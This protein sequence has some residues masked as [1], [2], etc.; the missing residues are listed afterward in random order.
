MRGVLYSLARSFLFALDPEVA[1][2]LTLSRLDHAAA[3]GLTRLVCRRVP[4]LPV[5][6]MGLDFRNPVGLAAGMDKNAAH[7]DALGSFGFGHIEA[8]TVTPRPQ[9]GNPKPRLFRLVPAQGLINRMGFNNDGVERFVAHVRAQRRFRA[10]GGILGLNIGKNATT[11]LER[12]ADDY[13]AGLR[14][15]YLDADYVAVNISSPNTKDLRAL[16]GERELVALLTALAD[17]RM[18]L[19][20]EHGRRV[21]LAVKIA[22][23]LDNAAIAPLADVLVAHGVDGVIATNTTIARDKVKGLAHADE[24][25]GLSG[26]PLRERATEVIGRLARHLQG[27]LP[28][29]G[30]GGIMSGADALEKIQAGATLVQIYTGFIYS[31]PDLVADCVEALRAAGGTARGSRGQAT[32]AA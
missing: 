5:Q 19:E 29:I 2:E 14:A 4:D 8:G 9:P 16:Q 10:A 21:P 15:V 17:A 22:P 20:D 6:A 18:R 1:H 28:I 31:G 12:A 25:G 26:L 3:L 13:I 30:V 27:R 11:P 24:A 32:R 7:I 23:D